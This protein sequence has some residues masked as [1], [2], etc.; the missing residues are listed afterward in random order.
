M[1][2]TPEKPQI[3]GFSWKPRPFPAASAAPASSW[4]EEAFLP[5]NE[6][7]DR[8]VFFPPCGQN[9]KWRDQ[10]VLKQLCLRLI[11]LKLHF[12]STLEILGDILLWWCVGIASFV[13]TWSRLEMR[14]HLWMCSAVGICS[15]LPLASSQTWIYPQLFHSSPYI[16]SLRFYLVIWR[17]LCFCPLPSFVFSLLIVYLLGMYG[18]AL[19]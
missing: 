8:S 16:F 14:A 4:P 3:T 18:A 6:R 5:P 2:Q 7:W 15:L 10:T 1:C 19:E 17:W 13:W 11:L 12:S 9:L